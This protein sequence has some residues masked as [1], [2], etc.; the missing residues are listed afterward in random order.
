[1]RKGELITKYKDYGNIEEGDWVMIKDGSYM[2]GIQHNSFRYNEDSH[3]HRL[4][5][6]LREDIFHVLAVNVP[7]PNEIRRDLNPPLIH[8]NNCI[9]KSLNNKDIFFCSSTNIV[10][11]KKDIDF[12]DLS[13][14]NINKGMIRDIKLD[15]LI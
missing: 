14:E 8:S 1:M 6:G 7:C 12:D 10:T 2:V 11:L 9:I 3:G 4:S 5:P 13:E 15:F